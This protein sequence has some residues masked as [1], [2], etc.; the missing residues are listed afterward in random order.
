[1]DENLQVSLV[2]ARRLIAAASGDAALLYLYL[3]TGAD[4]ENAAASLHMTPIQME[5]ATVCLRQLGLLPRRQ[6]RLQPE[7][8]RPMYTERDVARHMEDGREFPSLVGELQRVLGRV[9][10]TEELKIMLG[11]LDYLGLPTEVVAILINFCVERNRLRGNLRAP[12]LRTMEKEAYAWADEG[13]DTLERAV[14]YA[15]NRLNAQRKVNQ[16]A[17]ALQISDRRLTQGEEKYIRSWLDM[18]YDLPEIQLAY[19]RTCMNAGGLKWPYMNKIIL[20]WHSKNLHSV[21]GIL[22]TDR[23]PAAMNSADGK[24]IDPISKAA[25][26]RLMQEENW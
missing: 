2:D 19:E 6:R 15:Q 8:E 21:A 11:M 12:S 24:G 5:K 20:N 25:I 26:D 10:S 4:L 13:I 9:L 17:A 7:Q 14:A 23:P 18:G 1:M 16:V 3:K 22:E